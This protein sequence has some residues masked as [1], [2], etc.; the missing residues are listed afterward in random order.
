MDDLNIRP[1]AAD[2]EAP[3][4]LLLLADPSRKAVES[5]LRRGRCYVGERAG[6]VIAVYVLIDTRPHT[7]ELVNVAVAEA[8]QGRGIGKRMVLHAVET[9][10]SLGYRSLEVGTGNSSLN[11]LALYQ[12]CG[13]RIVGVDPDFFTRNYPEPIYENGIL[14]RDMIRLRLDL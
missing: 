12:K 8:E 5:Y 9:A 10:R 4:A 7:V 14:C 11:Q 13:F 2:E 6:R 1:L 3:M